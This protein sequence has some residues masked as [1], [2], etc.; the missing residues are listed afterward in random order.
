MARILPPSVFKANFQA[1]E[2]KPT[3]SQRVAERMATPEGLKVG[4]DVVDR[5]GGT[6]SDAVSRY[7]RKQS[8]IARLRKEANM[9]EE[10]GPF[11][12]Y[13][14]AEDE[15]LL[16]DHTYAAGQAE[17]VGAK[18]TA[19]R[20]AGYKKMREAF[21]LPGS[22]RLFT[23]PTRD[24]SRL[25]SEDYK[26][27]ATASPLPKAPE[28]PKFVKVQT[29]DLDNLAKPLASPVAHDLEASGVIAERVGTGE[30]AAALIA[31]AN[32]GQLK[33]EDAALL[34]SLPQFVV[35]QA[36]SVDKD[37][38]TTDNPTIRLSDDYAKDALRAAGDDENQ[39]RLI[40]EGLA[41]RAISVLNRSQ[42]KHLAEGLGRL[43]RFRSA[44]AQMRNAAPHMSALDPR[45]QRYAQEMDASRFNRLATGS[46]NADD[47]LSQIG[48][49][50]AQERALLLKLEQKHTD[51][52]GHGQDAANKLNK[53]EADMLFRLRQ[54]YGS[55]G[56]GSGE[57]GQPAPKGG[58]APAGT[59][60]QP[61]ATATVKNIPTSEA[62]AIAA[63]KRTEA[64]TPTATPEPPIPSLVPLSEPVT[65]PEVEVPE[66][67]RRPISDFPGLVTVPSEA[68]EIAAEAG[69]RTRRAALDNRLP[70]SEQTPRAPL[71][72]APDRARESYDYFADFYDQPF[73][74]A[75]PGYDPEAH[76]ARLRRDRT[77][78]AQI[79]KMIPGYGRLPGPPERTDRRPS[80]HT[81][82]ADARARAAR[83]RLRGKLKDPSYIP[84]P[85]DTKIQTL[86]KEDK[87]LGK[88]APSG[89]APHKAD[90]KFIIARIPK[91][92]IKGSKDG[93][94]THIDRME[95]EA[96]AGEYWRP[97][98]P[99]LPAVQE[100]SR[101]I[102][103]AQASAKKHKVDP[104]LFIA[105]L[106]QESK[107]DANAVSF[108]NA[109]GIGQMLVP[110]YRKLYGKNANPAD[111][112]K[113]EV[114]IDAAA[115][116]LAQNIK[117]HG[118]D[119]K[120]GV[121]SYNAGPNHSGHRTG[122][123]PAETRK[124]IKIILGEHKKK[125]AQ[126]KAAIA[127]KA[128]KG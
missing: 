89:P 23:D 55:R 39:K 2:F 64:Q 11:G 123:Y 25:V 5:V 80:Y 45:F 75:S 63:G 101:L 83:Q 60:S 14:S 127:E 56:T 77:P 4:L 68:E 103:L 118:G 88:R 74:Q 121:A 34:T 43:R 86:M 36:Q 113:P 7:A 30:E 3:Q 18:D 92:I 99:K 16:K 29:A 27:L 28:P 125:K 111:L 49:F 10:G 50:E 71:S 37:G 102:K 48:V 117:K 38:N 76:A 116:Y 62:L 41:R 67:A 93:Y 61:A 57:V 69:R 42:H 84:K 8:A 44:L 65:Y 20:A 108:A 98:T 104:D 106:R 110:T 70:L 72:V 6:I 33:P 40:R 47:Y 52:R 114:G 78:E 66:S 120:K 97:K 15:K 58:V 22:G 85:K 46:I 107:F 112:F 105:L 31:R 81:A 17:V 53:Q 124:Y 51:A 21:D 126:Q 91:R 79:E 13:A 35:H 96:K 90:R 95:K 100:R 119:I 19:Q 128:P 1:A 87:A 82:M 59:A 9:E 32:S 73:N 26:R 54:K 24:P 12:W 94:K 115:K 122:K 109:L